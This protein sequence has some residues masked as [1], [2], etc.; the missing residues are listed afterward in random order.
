MPE[1]R[2]SRKTVWPTQVETVDR[3]VDGYYKAIVTFISQH[4]SLLGS[5]SLEEKIQLQALEL[6]YVTAHKDVFGYE[7]PHLPT[8]R[9]DQSFFLVESNQRRYKPFVE[10]SDVFVYHAPD[11]QV[12]SSLTRSK[13]SGFPVPLFYLSYFAIQTE[14]TGLSYTGSTHAW[15]ACRQGSIPCSPPA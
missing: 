11:P 15:G 7:P 1:R 2:I 12:L 4:W 5:L 8:R 13:I 14:F 10:R 6:Q 3:R 9:Q